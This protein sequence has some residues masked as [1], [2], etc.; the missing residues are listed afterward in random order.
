MI[1]EKISYLWIWMYKYFIFN[2]W[3]IAYR[4]PILKNISRST[5]FYSEIV[6]PNILLRIPKQRKKKRRKKEMWMRQQCRKWT[7]DGQICV[8][9]NLHWIYGKKIHNFFMY[10]LV[11]AWFVCFEIFILKLHHCVNIT[12]SFE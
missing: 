1:N 7:A 10:F 9:P 4:L 6:N 3:V 2:L 12:G 11:L 5:I 8:H